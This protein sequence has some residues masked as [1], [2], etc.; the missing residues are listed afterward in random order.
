M[1]KKVILKVICIGLICVMS[2][3]AMLPTMAMSINENN[4]INDEL[5]ILF[6]GR[7]FDKNKLSADTLSWLEWYNSLDHDMQI[8]INY[9]PEELNTNSIDSSLSLQE[10]SLK[11]TT[12][13][14]MVTGGSEP[15]YNPS[16]WNEKSRIKK[17][18]CYAYAMD[19]ICKKDMK[20]QPG[21]SAGKTYTFLSMTHI[22]KAV[23]ADGPYLANG[24]S[25][26]D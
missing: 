15:I 5:K 11:N 24:R 16:Y 6:N 22:I 19:L 18:N 1:L 21:E 25:I 17:A 20:L 3:S 7:V 8:A 13:L 12:F 4:Y 10:E 9:I 26:R 2:I 23:K 14:D